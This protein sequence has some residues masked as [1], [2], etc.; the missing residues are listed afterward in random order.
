M[1]TKQDCGNMVHG[2]P[3]VSGCTSAPDVHV[4]PK[5]FLVDMYEFLIALNRACCSEL[6]K[7]RKVK[8]EGGVDAM[9]CLDSAH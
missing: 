6:L 5:Q 9:L 4:C 3:C 7:Y 2:R 8:G 1:Q